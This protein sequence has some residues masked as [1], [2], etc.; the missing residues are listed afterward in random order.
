MFSVTASACKNRW[1]TLRAYFFKKYRE[2]KTTKSGQAASKKKKWYLFDAMSFLTPYYCSR[3]ISGN[4]VYEDQP[5]DDDVD[6][7]VTE[8]QPSPATQSSDDSA[9]VTQE[10]FKKPPQQRKRKKD[11]TT[12]SEF[13]ME[14]LKALKE[15]EVLDET[16]MF[17]NSLL[18]SMKKLNDIQAMEFRIA[19]QSLLLKHLKEANKP[20][21]AA[22]ATTSGHMSSRPLGRLKPLNPAY[23]PISPDSQDDYYYTMT[24]F[25]SQQQMN[26]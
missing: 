23:S 8:S 21:D 19:V 9:P 11:C 16:E 10:I 14:V 26:Q 20:Q 17:L 12:T 18:P 3:V 24:P 5:E 7:G 6:I 22:E 4:L 13:N 2:S 15:P 1:G 25:N